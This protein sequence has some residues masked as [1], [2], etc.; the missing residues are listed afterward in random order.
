[1]STDGYQILLDT[2]PVRT[3]SRTVLTIPSSKRHLAEAIALEWD[4]LTSAQQALKQ[5]YIPLT[6]LTSRAADIAREDSLGQDKIRKEIT[7]VAKIFLSTDTLM[8]W[9]PEKKL[10]NPD[11][12]TLRSAQ[13]DA[14]QSVVGY[15]T[16]T[17]WPGV[18]ISPILDEDSILPVG[19]S[20]ATESVIR[21]WVASLPPYELAG[22]ERAIIACKSLLIAARLVVEWGEH[23]SDVQPAQGSARFGIDEAAKAATLEVSYQTGIWG[24]VEDTHDVNQVD[25]KRQLGGVI[26]LISGNRG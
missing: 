8:C 9:E 4:L 11:Q 21:D 26:L 2:R 15:L 10:H 14:A 3:P 16:Q 1:M 12:Q 17:V 23:F 20:A 7:N 25:I 18:E 24:E 22:L 19:Q 6:S 5:D 13:V